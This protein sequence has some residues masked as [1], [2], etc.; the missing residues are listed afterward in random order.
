MKYVTTYKFKPHLT[1]AESQQLMNIFSEAGTAP[2]TVA[3][4]IAADGSGGLVIAE[5]DDP[6]GAYRNTLNYSEYIEFDSK[7]MLSV[8]DAVPQIADYLGG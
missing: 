3:H 8:E 5:N 6:V 4:Y 1:K 7:V 2:G